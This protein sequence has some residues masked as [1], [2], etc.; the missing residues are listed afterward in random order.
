MPLV[1]SI[2]AKKSVENCNNGCQIEDRDENFAAD[3]PVSVFKF[4]TH[5]QKHFP[6]S[7]IRNKSVGL[8]VIHFLTILKNENYFIFYKNH[9]S[10]LKKMKN[11]SYFN[12]F[13]F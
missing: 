6:T 10:F 12:I 3:R 2:I 9:F 7:N 1:F 5:L 8:R 11:K 13:V 4:F